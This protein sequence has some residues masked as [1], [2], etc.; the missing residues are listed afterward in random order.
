MT[1]SS[2][3][4]GLS[5]YSLWAVNGLLLLCAFVCDAI[6]G[7][8]VW[9]PHP[10]RATG[11]LI[12]LLE[13]ILYRDTDEKSRKLR[14]GLLLTALVVLITALSGIFILCICHHINI[15]LYLAATL[16]MSTYCIAAHDLKK[17]AMRVYDRLVSKDLPG[18]RQAVAMIVGRDTENLSEQGVIKAVIES[19]AESLSD[20]V[21]APVFYIFLFG[22]AGGLVY[23]SINTMDSMI[24]YKNERYLYFGRA[25][26]RL[27]DICNYIPSRLSALLVIIASALLK[28]D[29]KHAVIIW[30]RDRRKHSSPNSAQT[31]SAVAGALGVRLGGPASYFGKKVEKPYLG[32][33]KQDIIADDIKIVCNIMYLSSFLFIL[34]LSIISLVILICVK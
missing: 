19:V 15:Y 23:K 29:F 21:I 22:P 16:I 24:G 6:I 14:K 28:C 4:S 2:L 18:A 34:L 33:I 17:A 26:A 30:K 5:G 9:L 10:V 13:Q 11:K 20:G 27:D 1:I 7:D 8:P 12:N 25:A 3:I 32:D 31:E